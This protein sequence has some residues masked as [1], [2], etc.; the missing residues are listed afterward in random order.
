LPPEE[1]F[2]V[3]DGF[4]S[5]A[6]SRVSREGGEISFWD[7]GDLVVAIPEDKN[8]SC[9][10]AACRVAIEI[11]EAIPSFFEPAKTISPHGTSIGAAAGIDYGVAVISPAKD[12][13]ASG[14]VV[15]GASRLM[16]I[17]N[18]RKIPIVV[19][20]IVADGLEGRFQ[21]KNLSEAGEEDAHEL[22]WGR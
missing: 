8:S 17:A 15:T 22:I 9:R 1:A 7:M 12:M 20:G 16:A 18:R 14:A 21:C 13:A 4:I 2:A 6:R 10:I 11:A 3:F 19:R 5:F